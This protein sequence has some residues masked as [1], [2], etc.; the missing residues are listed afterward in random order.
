[1]L[2]PMQRTLMKDARQ[3][4]QSP[5]GNSVNRLTWF[6]RGIYEYAPAQVQT[7][8]HQQLLFTRR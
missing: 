2:H 3:G 8:S 4:L 5:G 1:M 6:P 7:F